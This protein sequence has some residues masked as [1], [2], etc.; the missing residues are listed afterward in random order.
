MKSESP[1]MENAKLLLNLFL[2]TDV[3][4]KRVNPL[5]NI[6]IGAIGSIFC[7]LPSIQSVDFGL[8]VSP[9]FPFCKVLSHSIL[10]MNT[11]IEPGELDII[12]SI[13]IDSYSNH[14][15]LYTNDT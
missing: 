2:L 1:F 6:V 7:F 8:Q 12:I 3:P 4:F 5:A 15:L 13:H 11:G 10:L 9:T 14:C